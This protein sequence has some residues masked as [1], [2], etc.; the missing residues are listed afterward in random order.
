MTQLTIRT[1]RQNPISKLAFIWLMRRRVAE[2]Y[3][4]L[5]IVIK[6]ITSG[7]ARA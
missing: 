6:N 2:T 4:F 5:Q 1:D 3:Y 7:I